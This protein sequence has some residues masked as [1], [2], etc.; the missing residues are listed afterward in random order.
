MSNRQKYLR[1][2]DKL[3]Y[4]SD[5]VVNDPNMQNLL[6]AF[7]LINSTMIGVGTFDFV[8]GSEKIEKIFESTDTLFLVIFSIEMLLHFTYLGFHL[9]SEAW[10]VFDFVVIAISWLSVP[11]TIARAMKVL[12]VLRLITH[13]KVLKQLLT[14]MM[15]AVPKLVTI[16]SVLMIIFYAYAVMC[17][18]LFKSMY[19]DGKIDQDY[20]T[21]LD[22]TLFTLFTIMTMDGWSNVAW[23][24]MEVYP[25]AGLLFISF[26]IITSF[27]TVNLLIGVV[28]G[29]VR[30]VQDEDGREFQSFFSFASQ[31]D[32]AEAKQL[33]ISMKA[34]ISSQQE[35]IDKILDIL[36]SKFVLKNDNVTKVERQ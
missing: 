21:R 11:I 36:E 7:I 35:K 15:K 20:F 16:I 26:I 24:V 25:W 28:V 17:T 6:L 3:Q 32:S 2:L 8:T 9:F 33:R 27:I 30:N 10:L 22:K 5:R 19:E 1:M 29:A 13:M 34:S 18:E 12:R 14:A 4:L 23:Q 31:E